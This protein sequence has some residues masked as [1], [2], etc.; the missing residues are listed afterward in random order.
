VFL[1]V[2]IITFTISFVNTSYADTK[3]LGVLEVQSLN[4]TVQTRTSDFTV[5]GDKT[6]YLVNAAGSPVTVSLLGV[7]SKDVANR[8]Y[9]IKKTDSSN[10]KVTID[11][12]LSE[13]IDNG[14]TAVLENQFE[15]I[16]IVSDGVSN[17]G[18][19]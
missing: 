10:N 11:G 4:L 5:Q 13:T 19:H 12:L 1:T 16:M 15:S 7:T 18:I 8:T 3:V 14:L 17:W 6:V 9:H 2:V